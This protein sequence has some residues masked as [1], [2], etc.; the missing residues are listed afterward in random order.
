MRSGLSVYAAATG[1]LVSWRRHPAT[2][3]LVNRTLYRSPGRVGAYKSIAVT[4]NGRHVYATDFD[5]NEVVWW[6]R[7]PASGNLTNRSTRERFMRRVL[8]LYPSSAFPLFL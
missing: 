2:N 4:P 1:T 7:C 6:A 5:T 8:L 3:A